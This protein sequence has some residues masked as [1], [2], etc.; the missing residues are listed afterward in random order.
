M[1]RTKQIDFSKVIYSPNRIAP[2]TTVSTYPILTKT[3]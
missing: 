3:V 1:I 2:N